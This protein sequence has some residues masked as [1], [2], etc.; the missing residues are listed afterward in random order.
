M[1]AR[2]VPTGRSDRKVWVSRSKRWRHS[3]PT[4]PPTAT[5]TT[6]HPEDAVPV[7]KDVLGDSSRGMRGFLFRKD[8]VD[9]TAR[10]SP[11]H[12]GQIGRASCRERGDRSR[13]VE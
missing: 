9:P 2:K 12:L 11:Y 3:V 7:F 1:L 4:L 10:T 8:S 6:S 13:R 5:S